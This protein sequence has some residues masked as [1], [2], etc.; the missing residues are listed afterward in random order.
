MLKEEIWNAYT[1]NGFGKEETKQ[2]ERELRLAHKQEEAYWKTKSR[3]HWLREGDKNTKFFHAQTVKRRRFN[4][5]RGI[6]DSN[7][8]WQENDKGICKAVTS[9][10]S[11]L[12]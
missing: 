9:Y 6:E 5:I 12:F 11:E 7:G 2:K 3:I 10:F 4:Q 8:V 1:S